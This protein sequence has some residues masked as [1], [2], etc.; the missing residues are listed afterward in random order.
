MFYMYTLTLATM[1]NISETIIPNLLY[2]CLYYSV[3]TFQLHT[4]RLVGSMS[5]LIAKLTSRD[6]NISQA[7]IA[8]Y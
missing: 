1:E 7:Q 4:T 6:H 8:H 2:A 5:S 3:T